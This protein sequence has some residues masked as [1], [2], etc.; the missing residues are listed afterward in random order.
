MA[1]RTDERENEKNKKLEE[2]RDTTE[3]IQFGAL[4]VFDFQKKKKKSVAMATWRFCCHFI[5]AVIQLNGP[6]ERT[7]GSICHRFVTELTL[8]QLLK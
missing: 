3:L 1:G 6:G 7:G 5:A 2:W 8:I 4:P